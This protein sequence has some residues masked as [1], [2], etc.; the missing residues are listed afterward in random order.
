MLKINCLQCFDE[1]EGK[2]QRAKYCSDKCRK[3]AQRERDKFAKE[4]SKA[5]KASPRF[6]VAKN[7]HKNQAAQG[8]STKHSETMDDRQPN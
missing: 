5:M 8:Q 3:R 7:V 6:A 2:T 4:M 1:F